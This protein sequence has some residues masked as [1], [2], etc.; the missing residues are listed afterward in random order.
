MTTNYD[1]AKYFAENRDNEDGKKELHGSNFFLRDGVLYSYGEH[2]PV[3]M[4]LDCHVPHPLLLWNK[5]GYSN[6]TA[7]QKS[8]AASAIINAVPHLERVD[9]STEEF[10]KVLRQRSMGS[11]VCFIV[12]SMESKK[13]T[14]SEMGEMIPAFL[15]SQGCNTRTAN[16]LSKEAIELWKR[17]AVAEVL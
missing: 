8:Q 13:L 2:F 3:A 1:V 17:K 16:K 11:K 4:W 5:N 9:V 6:T 12:R 15:K 10:N 14:F 7:K